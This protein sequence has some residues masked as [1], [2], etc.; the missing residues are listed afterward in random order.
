[1]KKGKICILFYVDDNMFLLQQYSML[2]TK[3]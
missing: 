1:M 3:K 2:Y